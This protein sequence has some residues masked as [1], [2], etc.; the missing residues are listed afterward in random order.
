MTSKMPCE[1]IIRIIESRGMEGKIYK[2]KDLLIAFGYSST[3]YI[4][5]TNLK[6]FIMPVGDWGMIG[7]YEIS[8]E[9]RK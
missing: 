9:K 3:T 5:D 8:K 4:M 2:A 6:Q 1:K 7:Y